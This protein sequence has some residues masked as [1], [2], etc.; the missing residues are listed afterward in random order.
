MNRATLCR[1]ERRLSPRADGLVHSIVA[2]LE[3]PHGLRCDV[4]GQVHATA[5]EAERIHGG[6]G[7]L[8]VV[9]RIRRASP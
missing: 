1:L 7:V 5:D 8:V 3:T 6:P 9:E 2:M 4:C